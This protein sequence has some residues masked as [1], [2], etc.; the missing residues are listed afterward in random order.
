LRFVEDNLKQ[1]LEPD[2]IGYFSFTRKA[3]NEAIFRAV[4]KF[5][6]ERK[7]FKW[8][9]TLHSLAYQFLGCTHT[10]I[11]QDQD[12][13]EFKKEFG[14]DISNSINGTTM[15][16]GRDPDGI[17]LI[18]LYRVKNTTLYEE[19]RK[20]GHI[21]GGFERL[22]KI[23]KNYRMFKKEKGIKDYTDLITE[24]NKTK[25]SPKLDVVIVDEVQDLKASEWDM[26]NTM[27]KK[28]KTVYLAGDDDQA[29]YGWSGAEVSKLINLNCHLKVLNQSYRIPR[30]V[31]LR[32]N[33]LIGRIKNRIPK[34][35]KSRE[36]L[37]TVSNIN[38]ERLNLRENEWLILCRTNYYLNEI[39]S[40]LRAK[41]YLFE[42]NNK[43]SIKDDVLVAYN[44]W[45]HLQNLQEVSLS[46][47]RTMYQYIRS[48]ENGIARGKKKMPGAD[49]EKKYTYDV[50]F[51]EW[52]LKVDIKTPWDVALSGIG[53]NEV[54][55][56]R[57]ILKRGY[58]LDKKASVKLST[59]HGAKGG[60]SQNVVLFSDI[61]KR[62]VDEMAVNRDDERRVFYVGMTRAKENLFVIPS[63]S[64]YEFEE[65]LR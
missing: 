19:F 27:M 55:Y 4:N 24:F 44:C 20:A 12:F 65:I 17:H 61:S 58:D 23:D 56:M 14:V 30:N 3:A 41:G 2:R 48:G 7:E 49:E 10:D 35:W 38:F 57:Q 37:G 6:I 42:K 33:R 21:Q 43:L 25:S 26:V 8:F 13:E 63:T 29:I 62:I 9:R 45:R 53:E 18:D 51:E 28:A 59:I 16:S 1:E 39:A 5:K 64:Q 34:E 50:L 40:D 32:S 15:V 52:G 54:S 11:I 47:V 36:A 31:F 60:E 22:Q 46:D